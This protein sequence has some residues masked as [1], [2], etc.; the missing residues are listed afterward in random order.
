MNNVE[1]KKSKKSV[2][3]LE[4][5]FATMLFNNEFADEYIHRL[6]DYERELLDYSW[7]E[8]TEENKKE[9]LTDYIPKRLE[10]A[11]C[12]F[13]KFGIEFNIEN[14]CNISKQIQP[15]NKEHKKAFKAILYYLNFAEIV[16]KDNIKKCTDNIQSGHINLKF[17]P[18][19]PLKYPVICPSCKKEHYPDFLHPNLKFTGNCNNCSHYIYTSKK[20]CNR[21]GFNFDYYA[22]ECNCPG[23][24]NRKETLNKDLGIIK[25][26]WVFELTT[27]LYQLAQD[28]N[29]IK[30]S[31]ESKA[32]TNKQLKNY[33]LI[34]KNNIDKTTREILSM[35]PQN[36]NEIEEIVEQMIESKFYNNKEQIIKN[37][38]DAKV[39]YKQPIAETRIVPI[40]KLNMLI[41]DAVEKVTDNFA[42][43]LT[44]IIFDFKTQTKLKD[45]VNMGNCYHILQEIS[46]LSNNKKYEYVLNPYFVENIKTEQLNVSGHS[47]LK[48]NAEL[49]TLTDLINKYPEYLVIPNYPLSQMLDINKFKGFFEKD[50]IKYLKYCIFDFVITDKSGY[51][52]KVVECQKGKHHN[53]EE[54]I[55]KDNLKRKILE[56]SKIEFEEV[57]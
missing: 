37:L 38:L 21:L 4:E 9:I 52:A 32:I 12:E 20:W 5:Q 19:V 18:T 57:F 44:F 27:Q 53:C 28:V 41:S 39:I 13:N 25:K 7:S 55:A 48:S 45:T 49:C 16:D 46:N 3:E 50:E 51:I 29:N 10:E 54:W 6:F 56:L 47:I 8:L 26:K 40:E 15:N 31:R 24:K 36:Y 14:I 43:Q 33:Y 23:C 11:I 35:K 22:Y 42:R 2:Y 17:K 34:N 1:I 30:Y